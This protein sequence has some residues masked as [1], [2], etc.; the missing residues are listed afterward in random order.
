MPDVKPGTYLASDPVGVPLILIR[1]HSDGSHETWPIDWRSV[2]LAQ[3][4]VCQQGERNDCIHFV[5]K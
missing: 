3:C 1:V 4:A 5:A 2:A